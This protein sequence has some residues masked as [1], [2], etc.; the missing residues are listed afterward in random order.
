MP[1]RSMMPVLAL[2]YLR[3]QGAKPVSRILFPKIDGEHVDI[4][5]GSLTPFPPGSRFFMTCDELGERTLDWFFHALLQQLSFYAQ[6]CDPGISH[7]GGDRQSPTHVE[8]LGVCVEINEGSHAP[9]SQE[10][11]VN[12]LK[13]LLS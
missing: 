10:V 7:F 8:P 11:V 6:L 3:Q 4:R 13:E 5:L 1:D 12:R 2:P 9:T